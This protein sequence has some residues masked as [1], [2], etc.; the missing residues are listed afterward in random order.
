MKLIAPSF[1]F[2]RQLFDLT[3]KRSL[4]FITCFLLLFVISFLGLRTSKIELDIYYV[5]DPH[6]QSSIDLFEMKNSYQSDSQVILLVSFDEDPRYK[7]LCHLSEWIKKIERLPEVNTIHSIWSLRRPVISDSKLWY[8]KQ[9]DDPCQLNPEDTFRYTDD[10]KKSH[11]RHLIPSR[12]HRLFLFDFV[13]NE[14]GPLDQYVDN[15]MKEGTSFQSLTNVK[16]DLHYLG[17]GST[18]Y[19]FKKIFLEDS[20]YNLLVVL[21]IIFLLRIFY[22]TWRSGIYLTITLVASGIV[23]YGFLGLFG[24]T[25]NILT[26]NLFLMTAVAGAADFIFVT[27]DQLRG[28]YDESFQN[29]ITPCFF[30]TLTTIV[31][32]LSL[33]TSDLSIIKQFGNGAALGALCEWAMM[34]LFLPSM[35][36]LLKLN[37]V[38]VDPKKAFSFPGFNKLERM[39]LPRPVLWFFLVLMGISI[40]SFFFLNNQD[41]P[42]DNLPKEHPLRKGH[43]VFKNSFDWEGQVYLYFP[44][45]V[46]SHLQEQILSQ[47]SQ[48]RFIAR[49][50]SPQDLL[51]DWTHSFPELKKELVSR[52]LTSSTLWERYYS[53][54]G[55]LR[56]PVYLYHQDLHSLQGIRNQVNNICKRVCRLAGQR[57]VYLEYGEKISRTMIESFAVSIIL[58]LMILFWLL[59]IKNKLKYF[60]P[61]VISSLMGPL[62]ILSLLSIFQ[63]PVTIVTSIFLAVMVGLAGDNAIQFLFGS[64][65]ELSSGVE[66]KARSSIIVTFLMIAGSA[67]F[68]FQSL[69]PMKIIGGLFIFG[70]LINLI[71]DL[72]G[73]KSL[74]K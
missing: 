22:G 62:A 67:M 53:S 11:F 40:P 46:N 9:L 41:S 73:L 52:D 25:I 58:V 10:L 2:F 47:L 50:E 4:L 37:V 72:W 19:Y 45:R 24:G 66:G 65:G 48:S 14:D 28:E 36:K 71:G 44:E 34:F 64:D 27:Q 51:N 3:Q 21:I 7:D 16:M 26:N 69:I 59:K 33:N 70:F 5:F 1:S 35:L 20:V 39:K 49:I 42:V 38:W 17:N 74:L 23:L 30:T 13:L 18:R 60:F 31:G 54:S 29:L 63:I 61:L 6:F 57:V 8:R 12:G 43:E 68:L 56:I 15:I 32:F 55:S